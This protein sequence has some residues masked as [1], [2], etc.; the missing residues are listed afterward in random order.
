VALFISVIVAVWDVWVVDW[1]QS[2]NVMDSSSRPDLG[3]GCRPQDLGVYVV[4][5]VVHLIGCA[6]IGSQSR[7]PGLR[8][9]VC[10]VYDVVL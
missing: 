7:V 6:A 8:V 2:D 9:L 10:F 3:L 5:G 4:P 1:G